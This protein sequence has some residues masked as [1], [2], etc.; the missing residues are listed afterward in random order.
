MKKALT[1]LIAST[2]I[3]L[4]SCSALDSNRTLSKEDALTE[5]EAYYKKISPTQSELKKDIS[6]TSLNQVEELPEI[7]KTY[8]LKVEGQGKINAEIFVS[9]EKSGEGKD[10]ILNEIA[11]DF[12]N[13]HFTINGDTISVSIRS[14]P[15]G[16]A[17]DY[18]ST[19]KYVPDGYTPSN[20]QWNYILNAKGSYTTE[21]TDRLF[22]NTSGLLMKKELYESLE[23]EYGTINIDT[24]FKAIEKGKLLG[25]TNPYTSST[26][27]SLLTQL[28]YNFDSENPI[29][30]KAK[31]Q[32]K[33]L[34][35]NIPSTFVTTTQLRETA[36]SGSADI[37]SISY[38]TYINTPEFSDYKYVPLGIRQDS[39]LYSMTN[40]SNKQ[41]VLKKFS[42]FVRND[43]NQNKASSYGFNQLNDYSFEEQTKDGNLLLSIQN[44]WKK[45]KNSS[46]PIVGVFVTDVSGSMEGEPINKLKQ[47]LLNSL[48]YINEDNQI[49]LVSYNNNVTVNV[50]IASMDNN[51]KAY[52]T[53]AIKG[54]SAN[55]GTATFDGTL[56]AI[57]MIQDKMKE[58]PNARPVIFVL[59]DG[60]T[61]TGY[62]FDRVAPIIESLGITINTI[63]YNANLKELSKLSQINESVSIDASNE[64]VIYKLKE[65]FNAE[66]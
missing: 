30:D 35:E 2:S 59:S 44:L 1:L 37:L 29:S 43:N 4:A 16:T 7:E 53:S 52:F 17:N 27:L 55:G 23:K 64:D 36:K 47:S 66:F 42:E 20:K 12:N 9:T 56:V 62:S 26:G 45:N 31:E 24:L 15:S 49:G 34:Q 33:K 19:K 13:Q 39:P 18:I 58:Y 46:R 22:G 11:E 65:L 54:L 50:P 14:I 48:Q 41:E 38:Q 51:Q 5:V 63:G 40:N 57:K 61:N 32:F 8:P 6:N 10:G 60:E 25:Y 28:L 21:I 3:L